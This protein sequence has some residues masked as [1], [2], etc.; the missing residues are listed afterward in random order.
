MLY[1]S[2]SRLCD[3]VAHCKNGTDESPDLCRNYS[4]T[5]PPPV[6]FTTSVE[7]NLTRA[8]EPEPVRGSGSGNQ[9]QTEEL[10]TKTTYDKDDIV[11]ESGETE[12]GTRAVMTGMSLLD[13]SES[14][15]H[16]MDSLPSM[17][18]Q[19]LWSELKDVLSSRRA[20]ELMETLVQLGIGSH[21]GLLG[22]AGSLNKTEFRAVWQRTDSKE[23]QLHPVS[24]FTALMPSKRSVSGFS[25]NPFVLTGTV[26]LRCSFF[27][28]AIALHKRLGLSSFEKEL[29]L[30]IMEYRYHI[31][32]DPSKSLRYLSA[33]SSMRFMTFLI[34]LNCQVLTEDSHRS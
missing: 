7:L 9:S 1:I 26:R 18:G 28:Q 31:T 6:T 17:S 2:V 22:A 23:I 32:P 15:H 27:L 21:I 5:R 4:T 12:I 8:V 11:D 30:F 16:K 13:L 3:G 29:S 19:Q 25:E 10:L 33:L 24:L 14:I 34:C 20:G